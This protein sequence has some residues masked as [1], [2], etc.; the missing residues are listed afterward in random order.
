MVLSNDGLL[1]GFTQSVPIKALKI[2]LKGTIGSFSKGTY[3]FVIRKGVFC[4]VPFWKG[5]AYS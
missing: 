1:Q 2:V 3:P 4:F 5:T